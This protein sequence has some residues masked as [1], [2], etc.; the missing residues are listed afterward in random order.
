[1]FT[2]LFWKDAAERAVATFAQTVIAIVGVLA[3]LSGTDLLSF[4]YL[5][6]LLIGFVAAVLS[7]LKS[8]AASYKSNSSS[9]SLVD[10]VETI[11]KQ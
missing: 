9:A 11:E 6:V 10:S 7:V 8:I 4:N 1:M 3:P 2:R 5:P